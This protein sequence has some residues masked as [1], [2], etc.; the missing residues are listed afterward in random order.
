MSC[1]CSEDECD[2][3]SEVEGEPITTYKPVV[4]MGRQPHSDVYVL[5]PNLQFFSDGTVIPVEEQ[6]YVWVPRIIKNLKISNL[7][8]PITQLP[9]VH[10]PLN[11][12]TNG[13]LQIMG[14]NWP[15][16]IFILGMLN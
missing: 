5:G 1:I 14:E 16:T 4:C 13:I 7:L 2:S 11:K 10:Q 8:H 6:T 12:L 9:S 3:D 15:S